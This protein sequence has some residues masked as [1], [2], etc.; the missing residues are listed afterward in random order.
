VND[1]VRERLAL[2]AFYGEHKLC[3]GLWF[4][5]RECGDGISRRSRR[6]E[7]EAAAWTRLDGL[8]WAFT[9]GVVVGKFII[10]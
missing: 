6:E 9:L 3:G 4:Y 10:R 8:L 5:C 2:D 7:E 1:N